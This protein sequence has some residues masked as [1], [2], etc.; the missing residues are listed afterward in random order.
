MTDT[1]TH[2]LPGMD[3]GAADLSESLAMLEA[4]RLQGVDTVVL[5][6][7]FYPD[8]ESV[9]SFLQRR[10]QAYRQLQA[11]LTPDSPRL[12]LGA[13][14]AWCPGLEKMENICRLAIGESKYMLL[15][16]PFTAWTAEHLDGLWSLISGKRV[17]PV[18]AHVERSLRQQKHGQFQSAAS[19]QIPMQLSVGAFRGLFGGRKALQLMKQGQWMI[20]SDCHNM[21]TRQPCMAAA[22]E[23]LQHRA[24]ER[25]SALSW[26][27]D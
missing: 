19:M 20:G 26:K 12:V 3:D 13:E 22:A 17:M 16:M 9:E 2:I 8:R 10:E 7:H 27:F 11:A 21:T 6:P 15:E 23:Y 14:V 4:C 1:H 25:M 24:P 5:T 18:L